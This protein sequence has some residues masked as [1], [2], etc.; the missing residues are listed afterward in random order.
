M[1][2][3]NISGPEKILKL[4]YYSNTARPDS[5]YH[6]IKE[7]ISKDVGEFV[8]MINED[9]I[10]VGAV[11]DYDDFYYLVMRHDRTISYHSCCGGYSVK[12]ELPDSNFS[13]LMWLRDNDPESLLDLVYDSIKKNEVLPIGKISVTPQNL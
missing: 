8:S 10:L 1:Y 6:I 12:S 3:Y 13:V 5:N 4:A 2:W 7:E 9:G 11:V